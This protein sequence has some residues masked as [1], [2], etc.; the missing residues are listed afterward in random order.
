MDDGTS[1]PSAPSPI[2]TAIATATQESYD[3]LLEDHFELKFQYQ[4]IMINEFPNM[5]PKWQYD[6]LKKELKETK[7][8]LDAYKGKA[9]QELMK[10]GDTQHKASQLQMAEGDDKDSP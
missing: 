1:S 9:F 6:K 4:Q 7:E 10:R 5:I 2:A 8:E 3:K